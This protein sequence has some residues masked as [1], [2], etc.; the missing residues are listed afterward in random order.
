MDKNDAQPKPA[1]KKSLDYNVLTVGYPV[2][3]LAF[4]TKH[5]LFI[6]GGGGV[7]RSGVKNVI[8]SV[9]NYVYYYFIHLLFI[10]FLM[11]K[12]KK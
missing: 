10:K 1:A 9:L 11:L 4:T 5:R 2:F 6:G 8:V 7:N 3:S 12:K